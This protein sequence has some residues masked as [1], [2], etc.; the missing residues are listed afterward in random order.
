[1][2]RLMSAAGLEPVAFAPLKKTPSRVVHWVRNGRLPES[3]W[4]LGAWL[5]VRTC[6]RRP[7]LADYVE[8]VL[9]AR[10]PGGSTVT[11]ER[12]GLTSLFV[13][14]RWLR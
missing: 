9:V 2:E 8:C 5:D 6:A 7:D 4:G 12:P 1:V 14:R 11:Y 10:K 3:L 13:P